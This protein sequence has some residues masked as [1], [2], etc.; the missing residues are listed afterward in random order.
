VISVADYDTVADVN[1]VGYKTTSGT[2][3][4][5]ALDGPATSLISN[6]KFY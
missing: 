3:Y 2:S 1:G 5:I 4:G 6:F